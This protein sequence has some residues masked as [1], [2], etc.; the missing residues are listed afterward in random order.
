MGG[1]RLRAE[2]VQPLNDRATLL[3]RLD[4]LSAVLADEGLLRGLHEALRAGPTVDLD[5]LISQ[6]SRDPK[7]KTSRASSS[8]IANV[9]QSPFFL[10]WLWCTAFSFS[11]F[12][13]LGDK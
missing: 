13:D 11:V 6:F 9:V 10:L 12:L 3:M 7:V 8:M 2:L 1:K 4:A 5:L